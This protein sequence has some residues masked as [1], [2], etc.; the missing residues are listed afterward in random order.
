MATP[1]LLVWTENYW[2]GGC[3]RFLAD[4][5]RALDDWPVRISLAGNEHPAFDAW[6]GARVPDV[7]PRE[8]LPIA[9]LVR[10]PLHELERRTRRFAGRPRAV[11]AGYEA[12]SK[13]PLAR[14]AAAAAVRYGQDAVNLRRLVMLMRHRRPDVLLINNGGYPGGESCRVA[15][16]AA[17]RA[18]VPRILHFVHNMANP[19]AWPQP[20]ERAFDRRIDAATDVWITAA[21]RAGRALAARLAVETERVHTVH[22]GLPARSASSAQSSA[23]AA[24]LGYADDAFRL[25]AVANLEPRKGI[26]VLLEALAAVRDRGVAVRTAIIGDGPLRAPLAERTLQLGLDDRVR[27]TGWRDDV[28]DILDAAEALVLPSISHECLPYVILEAMAHHL[29]VVSTDVAGIPEMVRDGATGR[30]VAPGDAAALADA[31]D[32]LVCLEDRGRA[33][34]DRGHARLEAHFTVERMTREMAALMGLC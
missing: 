28:D 34:G 8:T 14:A 27:F 31:L 6:L 18:G 16:V 26:G 33:M 12:S 2:I 23:P 30:V 9:N 11:D 22:Y 20:L 13:E 10:S 17:R 32:Q 29:P 5:I 1:E 19:P 24:D 15:A 21:G 3:D 7:L 25:V 4:L